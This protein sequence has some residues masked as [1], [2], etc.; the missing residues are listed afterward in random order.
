MFRRELQTD[1]REARTWFHKGRAEMALGHLDQAIMDFR[2]AIRQDRD[3]VAP[4][5]HLARL[6]GGLTDAE[7]TRLAAICRE[8][9][10]ADERRVDAYFAQAYEFER[11]RQLGA[12]WRA[13]EAGNAAKEAVYSSGATTAAAVSIKAAFPAELLHAVG[14]RQVTEPQPIFVVGLPRSG[15]TLLERSLAACPEVDSIGEAGVLDHISDAL[16]E[17]LDVIVPK[18]ASQL[19]RLYLSSVGAETG[20]RVIDKN[21]LNFWNIGWINLI[22]P[23]ATVLH[24]RRDIVDTCVSCFRQNFD[25]SLSFTCGL[26]ALANYACVY[27]DLMR[28]WRSSAT[29]RLV[30]VDYADLVA[31]PED[32]LRVVTKA[33]DLAWTPDFL[34]G[35]NGTSPVFT[36]SD[37][38]VRSN[39]TSF[40]T[41][42]TRQYQA[43]LGPLIGALERQG[44]PATK[45]VA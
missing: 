28:H 7:L 36:A 9:P 6:H 43:H 42:A 20:R 38:Q 22:F 24:C 11:R 35:A 41:A 40:S 31:A 33:C 8:V 19:A 37:I 29:L 10:T 26:E 45:G 2:T 30:D 4:Y 39:L 17:R 14:A 5:T 25:Q 44:W 32:T 3:F 21:P 23:G 15:T 16:L 18:E 27:A 34:A 12:A 1:P 13:F